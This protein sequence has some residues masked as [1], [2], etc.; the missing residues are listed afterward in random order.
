MFT[1]A[2][3]ALYGTCAAKPEDTVRS[4]S[5]PPRPEV[6]VTTTFTSL[7]PAALRS[8]GRKAFVAYSTPTTFT[9]RYY[10]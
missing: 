9:L 8:K 10:Q 2:F 7:V 1:A 5:T 3:E 6:S 4:T